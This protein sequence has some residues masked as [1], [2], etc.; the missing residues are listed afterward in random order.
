MPFAVPVDLVF[1]PQVLKKGDRYDCTNYGI[2][3]KVIEDALV[4]L[5]I[6]PEDGPDDVL[7][8][9]TCTPIY[10]EE[11][12]TWVEIIESPPFEKL[13]ASTLC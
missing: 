2:T 4:N 9:K 10:G 3:T 6:L 5:G 7:S 11:S 13:L 1:T 8:I 12:G